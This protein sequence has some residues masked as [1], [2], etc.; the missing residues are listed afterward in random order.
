MG[1]PF[2]TD[3]ALEAIRIEG[4][5]Q[6]HNRHDRRFGRAA[7]FTIYWLRTHSKRARSHLT[8]SAARG[9]E[10]P[11]GELAGATTASACCEPRARFWK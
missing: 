8:K 11:V 5:Y 6:R 9:F 7:W 1:T 2:R 3:E 10:T 4:M